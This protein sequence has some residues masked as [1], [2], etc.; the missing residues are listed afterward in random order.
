MLMVTRA[1]WSPR[2]LLADGVGADARSRDVARSRRHR[3]LSMV[4]GN[5]QL[6]EE[7]HPAGGWVQ[8]V[9]K[10]SEQVWGDSRERGQSFIRTV[11]FDADDC[12]QVFST[13]M[14]R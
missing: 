13:H 5:R 2:E 12:V 11:R 4:F 14:S 7:P 9:G 3:F 6:R 1:V 10:F 8:R